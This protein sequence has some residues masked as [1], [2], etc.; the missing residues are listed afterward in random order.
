MP[1]MFPVNVWSRYF[2]FHYNKTDRLQK[3]NK[4][5]FL[6]KIEFDLHIVV[7]KNM[8]AVILT[9]Q[10]SPAFHFLFHF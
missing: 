3:N 1:S 7:N 4:F 10:S 9:V 2:I 6:A 8:A 5:T